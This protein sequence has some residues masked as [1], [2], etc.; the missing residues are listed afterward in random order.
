MLT[1]P[2]AAVTIYAA[3]LFGLYL[4]PIFGYV[5]G[6]HWFHEL[7]MIA[8]LVTG[9]FL[10]WQIVGIDPLPH[11]IPHLARLGLVVVLMPIDAVFGI[12]ILTKQSV[13]GLVFYGYLSLPWLPDQLS[14]Q[15]LGALIAWIGG[16]IPLLAVVVTLMVQ[17]WRAGGLG[18]ADT[19]AATASDP[20]Q[21]AWE[22]FTRSR[23]RR[24]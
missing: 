19:S 15:R 9:Y 3:L 21:L 5:V 13:M 10:Y 16:E 12:A 8:F 14:D 11:R 22:E 24:Q 23:A 2:F 7:A 1:N 17:W 18:P 4:T 20:G 6:Y